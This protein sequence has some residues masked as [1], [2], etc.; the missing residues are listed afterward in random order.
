MP[1]AS[2]PWRQPV[3]ERNDDTWQQL[4]ELLER[5]LEVPKGER[6]QF[7]ATAVEDSELRDRIRQV[8]A[9]ESRSDFL[10]PDKLID[11]PIVRDL[12]QELDEQPRPKTAG[13]Y[14]ILEE[15]GRGGM[16][17]VYR[18]QR[19]EGGFEQQ[20]AI[21][22]IGKH[23]GSL[24]SRER[25]ERERQILASLN[26]PAIARLL[27]G[28][29]ADGR[30][31]FAM[32]LVDG[33]PVESYCA[34]RHLKLDTR[35]RLFVQIVEAVAYAHRNLIVHRDIKSSNVL[36]TAQGE[37]K[38]LDFGIAKLVESQASLTA[39]HQQP[40]TPEFASPE[41]VTGDPVTTVSDVYQL[42]HL[43]Y[44][45]VSGKSPYRAESKTPPYLHRAI[46]TE[47]PVLPSVAAGTHQPWAEVAAEARPRQGQ[48]D[49]VPWASELRG[50]LDAIVMMAMRKEPERRYATVEQL[51][52]DLRS[53]LAGYP[54][55]A[56]PDSL[57]Y[58]AR[59]LVTRNWAASMIT[60][61]A[62]VAV[63]GVIVL[64]GLRLARERDRALREA[65]RASRI[66]DFLTDTFRASDPSV[67]LGET[68]TARDLLDRGA[69]K[70]TSDL[71]DDPQV[72]ASLLETMGV[73][74]RELGAYEP[75]ADALERAVSENLA[76]H[77]VAHVDTL[78]AQKQLGHVYWHQSRFDESEELLSEAY[79]VARDRLGVDEP[80]T[81]S[82]ANHLGLSWWR[83]GRYDEAEQ[84]FRTTLD[85]MLRVHGADHADTVAVRSNL[86]G[87]LHTQGRYA[88]SVAGYQQ[89]L[90][91]RRE[92]LPADH[93][94][95][96]QAL[97]SLGL[98]YRE[99]QDYERARPL[100]EEAA[101]RRARVLGESHRSTLGARSA[102]ASLHALAG[103]FESALELHLSIHRARLETLGPA[104]ID[105]L[106]SG[107][108]VAGTHYMAGNLAK[109]IDG[110]RENLEQRRSIQG[111]E[112]PST[113]G[114][115][116]VLAYFLAE[117]GDVD[118]AEALFDTTLQTYLNAH[119]PTHLSVIE[120]R[121][122]L[123]R[124]R[125]AHS[126]EEGLA[127]LDEALLQGREHFGEDAPLT[128]TV[129]R[130]RGRCLVTLNRFQKAEESLLE[131]HEI[132]ADSPQAEDAEK[133]RAALVH[134]Y[135]SWRRPAEARAWRDQIVAG[136]AKQ[137]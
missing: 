88:D 2:Q 21:K 81:L 82:L 12:E 66:A 65:E 56:R 134:L 1:P 38:L 52:D 5:I 67:A 20:V 122:E 42:G 79:A 116:K 29:E 90:G 10:D 37:V 99:L 106:S 73:A 64:S 23:A 93:S 98:A 35:L 137:P 51:L 114:T 24:S 136:A 115:A 85:E 105:T 4:D 28:G 54:I 3:S 33:E 46:L 15:I 74:Y 59:K 102:L 118:A 75:A 9:E 125:C 80:L 117:A 14:Q 62:F 34:N 94:Q 96:L 111:S 119:S 86:A 89:V 71:D 108:N 45:L 103:D 32:E 83:L 6:E 128:G 58:R 47:T 17:R 70:I 124:L 77:G 109:A 107:Q 113:L 49:A 26:H 39:T 53:Y 31:W 63:V 13:P 135:E 30:P 126:G 132:L 133:T 110:F 60:L 130:E 72:K 100:L 16:A 92:H 61:V 18:A 11:R 7:L 69:E 121:R 27:D 41:Q 36:V 68:L 120:M 78:R 55:K 95:T 101:E 50:D 127:L 48:E 123:G 44:R 57:R 104:H 131:S 84:L 22:V 25:F 8:L 129:F 97:Y 112:H 91:W 76:Q 19:V 87:T 43:L 40:M